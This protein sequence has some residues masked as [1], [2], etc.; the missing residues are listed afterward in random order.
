M[1]IC[2][3]EFSRRKYSQYKGN[4]FLFSFMFTPFQSSSSRDQDISGSLLLWKEKELKKSPMSVLKL[5]ILHFI[6]YISLTFQLD[7]FIPVHKTQTRPH[8]CRMNRDP[9]LSQSAQ[10][11][12]LK[13]DNLAEFWG[14]SCCVFLIPEVG[15]L[16]GC[17]SGDWACKL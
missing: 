2:G 14:C 5:M 6:L 10:W 12:T 16:V 1:M 9:D 11:T 13:S 4:L 15:I 7:C 3:V 8:F 17:L